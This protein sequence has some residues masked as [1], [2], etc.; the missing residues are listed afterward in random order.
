MTES[1][2][3]AIIFFSMFK[4]YEPAPETRSRVKNGLIGQ[5]VRIVEGKKAKRYVVRRICRDGEHMGKFQLEWMSA[6]P[7]NPDRFI[8]LYRKEIEE[9]IAEDKAG[10]STSSN[11]FTRQVTVR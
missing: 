8:Y 4:N 2:R 6:R 3:R 7:D 1:N 5:D 11:T 9:R 10:Q